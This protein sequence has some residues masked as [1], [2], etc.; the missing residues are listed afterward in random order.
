M[1]YRPTRSLIEPPG[2]WFSSFRNSWHGPVS[3]RRTAMSGVVPIICSTLPEAGF[4]LGAPCESGSRLYAMGVAPQPRSAP[5]QAVSAPARSGGA[6][7]ESGADPVAQQ[8]CGVR[9]RLCLAEL[10][11]QQFAQLAE[12]PA[13]ACG[14]QHRAFRV[15]QRAEVSREPV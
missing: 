14:I 10:I 13:I 12:R 7:D 9:R 5:P 15:C 3:R 11:A 2:F 8:G 4:D 6:A 1:R